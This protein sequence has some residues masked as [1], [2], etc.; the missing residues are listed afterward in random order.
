M[1]RLVC[2]IEV[3]LP[4]MGTCIKNP[5][6]KKFKFLKLQYIYKI[7]TVLSLNAQWT[8]G[9]LRINEKLS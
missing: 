9:I 3:P 6:L 8:I 1:C 4:V 2:T 7:L 5:E